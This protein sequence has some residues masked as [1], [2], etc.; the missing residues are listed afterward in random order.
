MNAR[1]TTWCLAHS[2]SPCGRPATSLW[3]NSLPQSIRLSRHFSIHSVRARHHLHEECSGLRFDN[4]HPYQD[5]L[6]RPLVLR[7][8]RHIPGLGDHAAGSILFLIAPITELGH[9]PLQDLP[10]GWPI[11]MAMDGRYP[12]R[13]D[14]DLAQ[15]QLVIGHIGAEINRA[16][17]LRIDALILRRG[18]LLPNRDTEPENQ[19]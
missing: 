3:P 11:L 4:I 19:T 18:A 13:L 10:E 15:P 14:C 12:T 8:V 7:P 9:R 17:H 16:D 6:R 5:R 2:I 1:C